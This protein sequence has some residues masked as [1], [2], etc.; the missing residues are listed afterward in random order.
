VL[1]A[2]KWSPFTWLVLLSSVSNKNYKKLGAVPE[3][4]L[5]GR[6]D[7]NRFFVRMVG[8]LGVKCVRKVEEIMNETVVGWGVAAFH[9]PNFLSPVERIHDTLMVQH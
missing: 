9:L 6:V 4:I 2:T 5:R 7:G 8:C 3:I 1:A